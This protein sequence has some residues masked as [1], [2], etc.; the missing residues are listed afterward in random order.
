MALVTADASQKGW[1]FM[2]ADRSI[3]DDR[4]YS[5]SVELQKSAGHLTAS[6]IPSS[7]KFTVQ[8][9]LYVL[10]EVRIACRGRR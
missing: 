4:F 1:D 5:F 2:L 10:Q 6:R 3:Y 8:L 9:A 7:R